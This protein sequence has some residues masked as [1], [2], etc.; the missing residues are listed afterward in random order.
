MANAA[1]A[2]KRGAP[3]GREH[4]RGS[5]GGLAG[6]CPDALNEVWSTGVD[7]QRLEHGNEHVKHRLLAR[8]RP[9]A[10][11]D[12]GDA[13]GEDLG[14]VLGEPPPG[15]D[16]L[17]GSDEEAA[18]ERPQAPPTVITSVMP[19]DLIACPVGSATMASSLFT[20]ASHPR[21]MLAP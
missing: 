16:R 15:G 4:W 6:N 1:L 18:I 14:E 13:G 11:G 3:L 19:R 7:A 2:K 5:L 9:A 17:A 21:F 10:R 20:M 12:G 8:S